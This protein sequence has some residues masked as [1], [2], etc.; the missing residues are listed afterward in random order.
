MGCI[1]LSSKILGTNSPPL[2]F[3]YLDLKKF[4]SEGFSKIG[5]FQPLANL[6]PDFGAV[7]PTHP[8]DT[9]NFFGEFF[10]V[11]F[12]GRD[13]HVKKNSFSDHVVDKTTH[14]VR[15]KIPREWDKLNINTTGLKFQQTRR[16]AKRKPAPAFSLP[17]NLPSLYWSVR[18]RIRRPRRQSM[19]QELVRTNKSDDD[20]RSWLPKLAQRRGRG[21][22][23][24]Q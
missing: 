7:S 22:K 23:R 8:D 19:R 16:P 3:R 24:R 5:V 6:G 14:I 4:L 9:S 18:F 1:C 17:S 20:P 21:L 15:K 12:R 11:F 10:R 2:K 13:A